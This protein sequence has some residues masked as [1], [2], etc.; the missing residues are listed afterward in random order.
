M[1]YLSI[2]LGALFC[3]SLTAC[4]MGPK[5]SYG[6]TLPEGN[7]DY[8]QQYFVEFRCIDCH[9]VAN[10]QDTLMIPEGIEAI[11]EVPIGGETTKIATYGQLV[12]SIINPSHKVSDQYQVTPEIGNGQSMMRNY[13]TIMTVDEL[14][15]IVAF[16]QNQY[17]LKP[18]SPTIYKMY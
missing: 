13:N 12:T 4:D 14:I 3:F 5:S 16:I 11:M 2:I 9:S 7:A 17:V 18:V 6:F 1:K 10:M 8:G 15:D